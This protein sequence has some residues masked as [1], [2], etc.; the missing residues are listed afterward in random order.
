[1]LYERG[2]DS[3]GFGRILSKGDAALFGGLS[4]QNMKDRLTVPNNRP[5]A[6]FL[7]TITIKAKDFVNEITNTQLKQQ[8]LNGESDITKEHVKNNRD[9]RQLLADRNIVPENL[10]VAEDVKKLERCLKF[11]EKKLTEITSFLEKN[12]SE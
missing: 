9:V 3:Q 12:K 11:E 5:L 2:V 1:M 8:N 4:T 7:P 10:P 6:D